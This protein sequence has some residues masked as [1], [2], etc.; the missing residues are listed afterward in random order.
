M[1]TNRACNESTI[2]FVLAV[3]MGL[4]LSSL[5][6]LHASAVEVVAVPAHT[7]L[8]DSREN[9]A[10]LPDVCEREA[11]KL[12][13][14]KAIR[15]GRSVPAPKQLRHVPPKYPELS[16]GTV[17]SGVWLGEVLIDNTGKVAHVWPIREV[18]FV[19]PFPAFNNVIPDAIHQWAFE[20]LRVRGKAAAF[21]MTVTVNINW[22]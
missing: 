6:H 14:Q 9:A 2:R 10:A 20:P 19:P 4:C 16:P 8:S 17:A 3:A 22:Q 11:E 5:V 7:Q 21:C 18:K 1:T 13:G 12:V 15:I